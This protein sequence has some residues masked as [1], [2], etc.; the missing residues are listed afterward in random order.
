M[1][2]TPNK[3][4]LIELVE[5][6]LIFY[7][8]VDLTNLRTEIKT[9]RHGCLVKH[10]LIWGLVIKS[11][12]SV[13]KKQYSTTFQIYRSSVHLNKALL[14]HQIHHNSVTH[15]SGRIY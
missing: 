2:K 6:S 11:D 9:D 13:D 7:N 1:Y 14:M 4:Q 10:V 5:F 15:S 12:R 3:P 8:K